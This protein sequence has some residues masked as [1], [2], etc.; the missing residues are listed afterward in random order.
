[1]KHLIDRWLS[2]DYFFINLVFHKFPLNDIS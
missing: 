1:M 2:Y